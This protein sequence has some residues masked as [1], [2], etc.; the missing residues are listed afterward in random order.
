MATILPFN[1]AGLYL[2]QEKESRKA[3]LDTNILFS[4][5]YD[6]D[7]FH[8]EVLNIFSII[9]EKKTKIYSNITT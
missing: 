5:S 2:D 7:I 6:T 1:D 3:F 4:Y 8:D 9:K